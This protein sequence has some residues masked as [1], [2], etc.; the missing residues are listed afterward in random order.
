MRLTTLGSKTAL[1]AAVAAALVIS[2][3]S[4]AQ[5]WTGGFHKAYVTASCGGYAGGQYQW[6]RTG[7]GDGDA[8]YKTRWDLN[9]GNGCSWDPA[10]R[11][12]AK[13][14]KWTGGRWDETPLHS[15]QGPLPWSGTG[16]DLADVK[17]Y[18]CVQGRASTCVPMTR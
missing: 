6:E 12:Y 2:V 9:G 16:K 7:Q 1:G 13:W 17:L 18:A 3:P 10:I 5:A 4:T 11:V 14:R 15:Y 8:I